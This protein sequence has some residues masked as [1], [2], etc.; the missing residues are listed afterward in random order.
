MHADR[1]RNR[2]ETANSGASGSNAS[3]RVHVDLSG[4]SDDD[5]MPDDLDPEDSDDGSYNPHRCAL[6]QCPECCCCA[7]I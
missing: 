1:K 4:D 2:D 6:S 3:G 5:S 7:R